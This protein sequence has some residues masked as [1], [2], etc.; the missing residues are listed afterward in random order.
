MTMISQKCDARLWM[1]SSRG[2]QG[3]FVMLYA[4]RQFDLLNLVT[5]LLDHVAFFL[6]VFKQVLTSL[7]K[8]LTSP[9]FLESRPC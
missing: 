8:Q 2:V 6:T 5:L 3:I 4:A 9:V 1:R 7:G